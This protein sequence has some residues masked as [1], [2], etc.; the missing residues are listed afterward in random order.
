MFCIIFLTLVTTGYFIVSKNPIGR[1]ARMYKG[2][3]EYRH[4]IHVPKI[5]DH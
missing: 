5:F 2:L 1:C 3:S 4:D